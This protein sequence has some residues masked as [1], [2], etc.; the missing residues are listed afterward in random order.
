VVETTA[1]PAIVE[2]VEATPL[3]AADVEVEAPAPVVVV[4]EPVAA[5]VEPEPVAAPV[6]AEPDPAEISAP[7]AKPKRGWWRRG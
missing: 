2:P 3:V 7:P 5:P 4:A 6:A 1:E